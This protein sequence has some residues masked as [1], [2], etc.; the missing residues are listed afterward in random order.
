MHS[1][2][3]PAGVSAGLVNWRAGVNVRGVN[4][5][6][7]AAHWLRPET[8]ATFAD[9]CMV[10]PSTAGSGGGAFQLALPDGTATGGNKRGSG[11]ADLQIVRN[12]ASKVAS[13]AQSFQAGLNNTTSAT[14]SAT[15]GSNNL[16]AG[17]ATFLMG[18]NLTAN[19]S[20]DYA[21]GSG[22]QGIMRAVLGHRMHAY[23]VAA[24]GDCQYE[25]LVS[26]VRQTAGPFPVTVGGAGSTN[27]ANI[28]TCPNNTMIGFFCQVI[29]F[30]ASFAN[31]YAALWHGAMYRSGATI[32]F[33]VAPVALNVQTT[34]TGGTWTVTPTIDAA[35]YGMAFQITCGGVFTQWTVI[36]HSG[37]AQ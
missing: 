4:S 12:A 24:Q 35:N 11:A 34:G 19:T 16:N 36:T 18:D 13:G 7:V 31:T 28:L 14:A 30:Q 1:S 29:G 15:M 3:T 33:I 23:F 10:V 27:T 26:G 5:A 6:G 20:S 32:A 25:R 9:I 8:G 2:H 21:M 22:R 17:S 37:L